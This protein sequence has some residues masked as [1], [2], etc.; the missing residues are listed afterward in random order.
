M[1]PIAFRQIHLDFHTSE[2]ITP[3]CRDFDAEEFARTLA[4]AHVNS[5]TCFSKCHHGMIYEEG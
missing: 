5:V 3:I 4:E 2:Q 1:N